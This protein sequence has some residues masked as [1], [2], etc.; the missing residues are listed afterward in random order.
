MISHEVHPDMP[1]LVART[2]LLCIHLCNKCQSDPLTCRGVKKVVLVLVYCQYRD[3]LRKL[4]R[5]CSDESLILKISFGG[6]KL[7]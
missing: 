5:I 2:V 7:F 4:C 1:Q 6:K 3:Y